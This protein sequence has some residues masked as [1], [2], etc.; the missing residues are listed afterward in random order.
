[1]NRKLPN[2]KS[3]SKQ[4]KREAD[5]DCKRVA[6]VALVSAGG[7][8]T[9]VDTWLINGAKT[10][11]GQDRSACARKAADNF[12]QVEKMAVENNVRLAAEKV[13][14]LVECRTQAKEDL[15]KGGVREHDVP[16]VLRDISQVVGADAWQACM[17][18]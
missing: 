3:A 2:Y 5:E 8:R 13:A 6:E 14:A 10:Q 18:G 4:N 12:G 15:E 11:T 16:K 9:L 1:M 17:T 7:D